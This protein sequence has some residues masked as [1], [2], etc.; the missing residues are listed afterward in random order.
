ME[1]DNLINHLRVRL[2]WAR[3]SRK[4]GDIEVMREAIR[5]LEDYQRL[6]ARPNRNEGTAKKYPNGWGT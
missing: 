4:L 3:E 5:Y 1:V 2:N 6:L